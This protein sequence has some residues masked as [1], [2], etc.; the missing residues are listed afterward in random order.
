MESID[1]LV[2]KYASINIA[3]KPLIFDISSA[4]VIRSCK[5]LNFKTDYVKK[6]WKIIFGELTEF[7]VL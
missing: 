3:T 2:E 6:V 1:Y 4:N 7:L 5:C